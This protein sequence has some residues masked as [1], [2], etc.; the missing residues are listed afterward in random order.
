VED[1]GHSGLSPVWQGG[2]MPLDLRGYLEGSCDPLGPDTTRPEILD[3]PTSIA[4]FLLRCT[5]LESTRLEVARTITS[6]DAIDVPSPARSNL[7]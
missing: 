2:M 7:P 5:K 4:R 1:V 3:A 6:G